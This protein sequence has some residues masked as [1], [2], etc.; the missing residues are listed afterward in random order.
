MYNI[1]HRTSHEDKDATVIEHQISAASVIS[2]WSIFF[3]VWDEYADIFN[4]MSFAIFS[5][6]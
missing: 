1:N 2:N 5:A 3:E 4:F 6:L